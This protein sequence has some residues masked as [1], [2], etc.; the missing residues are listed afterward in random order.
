MSFVDHDRNGVIFMTS[1][2]IQAAHA[3]TTRY[4]GVSEGIYSSLNLGVNCGDD[5]VSVE[6]NYGRICNILG[7]TLS[8][9][10]CSHQIHSATIRT[11]TREDCGELFKSSPYKADG[12]ITCDNGVALMVFSADCVPILLHDPVRNVIGAIHAGWRGTAKNITGAAIQKMIGE[13]GC[14]PN[15]ICAAIGPCISKCCYETDQDVVNALYETLGESVKGC[16]VTNNSTK[17][18]KYMV[19]LKEANRILLQKAGLCDI[20][21]SDECTSCQN[22]KYWSH[23]RTNGKRGSQAA[24]IK[25]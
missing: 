2:N 6:E 7:I 25:V 23:R 15:E 24:I 16:V 14:R 8:D 10:V 4:G 13:F 12:L 17:G 9:I 11:V 22:D 1:P 19:D 18:N 21:V 3:F 20:M 5:L